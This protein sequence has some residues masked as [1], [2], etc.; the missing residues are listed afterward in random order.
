MVGYLTVMLFESIGP[1][2][3]FDWNKFL[4]KK[5]WTFIEVI[6]TTNEKIFKFPQNVIFLDADFCEI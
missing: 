3:K 6:K 2:I 1:H 5:F 4:N